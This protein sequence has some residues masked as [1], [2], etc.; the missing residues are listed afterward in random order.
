MAQEEH[1]RAERRHRHSSVE[2]VHSPP[3]LTP[4][5]FFLFKASL[6]F[7]LDMLTVDNWNN[8]RAHWRKW[9]PE[10][11]TGHTESVCATNVKV[12]ASY[13]SPLPLIR[14]VHWLKMTS[15]YNLNQSKCRLGLNKSKLAPSRPSVILKREMDPFFSRVILSLIFLFTPVLFFYANSTWSHPVV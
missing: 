12:A 4:T 10:R 7:F 9:H 8:T 14:S 5:V 11:N 2:G 3:S 15:V 6:F 13:R 1:T